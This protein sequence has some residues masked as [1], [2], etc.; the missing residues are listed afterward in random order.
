MCGILG[1]LS[2]RP[3][4]P[5]VAIAA[6]DTMAHRGPDGVGLWQSPDARVTLGHRRLAVIVPT[7]EGAQPMSSIDGRYQ[8]TFNGEIYNYRELRRQLVVEGV[9]FRTSTDTEVLIEA[10][11]RW[12]PAALQRVS[13]MF[14][15]AL[16]DA[17]Q[18]RL[19]LARDRAGEKPL[20]YAQVGRDFVFASELKG[21]VAWPGFR[22][23][24]H[25]P[26][27]IDFLTF[28]FVADPKSIWEG[29]FKL[30]PA[31]W[32]EVELDTDGPRIVTQPT[33][34]WDQVF[35]PEL[36]RESW[37]EEIRA[38]IERA[39]DEM[40]VADVPLGTFLSGGVDSSAVTAALSRSGHDVRSFTIGFTESAFD[41]RP[42]AQEV[43][44]RY[45][46]THTA[47]LVTTDDVA[48]VLERL[49]WHYDEPCNDYSYLPTYYL[50][51][52]ARQHITVALSGDGGDEVFAGY[53]KYQ[54]LAMRAGAERFVPR[55]FAPLV[56]RVTGALMPAGSA[57]ARTL[58][59]YLG[60]PAVVLTD[61]LTLGFEGHVLSAAARGPLRAALNDY[62]PVD[63]VAA[64]LRNA[65]PVDVGLVDA[66]R[67]LDLKLTLAGGI[68]AKVDRASM[69]VS[70]EVR[71]VFLH[72]ELL[73]LAARIPSAALAGRTRAKHALK[74]ALKPWLPDSVLFRRKQ[75]FALPLGE[76]FRRGLTLGRTDA[77]R[78]RSPVADWLDSALLARLTSQHQD[79]TDH[80][81]RLH[82]VLLLERWLE[83]WDA[84]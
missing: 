62:S 42:Y 19:L 51:R 83:R 49:L 16:W 20:Y 80:T 44:D 34:Y 36:D 35:A 5:N 58:N 30:P 9:Q 10:C 2:P 21:I 14:A 78:R 74:E 3:I 28:G 64:H 56:S 17:P 6:R 75:G 8:I 13:G 39:T 1:A 45:H 76:W 53:R 70:L 41:E 61:A 72:R 24:I 59:H 33:P 12:G 57:A 23:T 66:M 18:R 69:A 11:R 79:G 38:T 7:A 32:M 25:Q 81:A 4:D 50:C 68:L 63:T 31:H 22:R 82:S 48:P 67:Y 27:L 40:A 15:F 52:S 65:P 73:A 55:P 43:A 29:C 37:D 84:A 71:P 47:E 46:T 60:D 77:T 26:A 54:R